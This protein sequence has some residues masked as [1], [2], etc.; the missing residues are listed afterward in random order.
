MKEIMK[1]KKNLALDQEKEADIELPMNLFEERAENKFKES[2]KDQSKAETIEEIICENM[3]QIAKEAEPVEKNF[4]EMRKEK[5]NELGRMKINRDLCKQEN[6]LEIKRKEIEKKN[7]ENFEKVLDPSIEKNFKEK[8]KEKASE[9]SRMKFD[10][11]FIDKNVLEI[12]SEDLENSEM[13]SVLLKE[14]SEKENIMESEEFSKTSSDLKFMKVLNLSKMKKKRLFLVKEKKIRKKCIKKKGNFKKNFK[15]NWMKQLEEYSFAEKYSILKRINAKMK[16]LKISVLKKINAKM[17][18]K[19]MKQ[20]KFGW[21]KRKIKGRFLQGV[22]RRFDLKKLIT[23]I[24]ASRQFRNS[25]KEKRR[26]MK[27]LRPK[28]DLYF[29]PET[30]QV[31]QTSLMAMTSIDLARVPIR[32]KKVKTGLGDLG[33]FEGISDT[34]SDYIFGLTLATP[35][36]FG[37]AVTARILTE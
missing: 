30:K 2:E 32:I 20:E 19:A 31:I 15:L 27:N 18:R 6:S 25:L 24:R 37:S 10:Y 3:V 14:F 36:L 7:V 17:K 4:E 22:R 33:F 28:I 29:V 11:E 8:R 1:K 35:S 26:L 12:R 13:E 34:I 21:K 9:L 5:A 16:L 23:L